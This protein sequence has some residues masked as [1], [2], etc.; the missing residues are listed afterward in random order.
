MTAVAIVGM[1]GRFAGAPDLAS[2]WRLVRDGRNAFGPVPAD[3]WD[4][5]AFHATSGRDADR[6][7]APA[8]AFLDDVRT[9]PALAFGIPP[10]R[11]E[12]MD[13]QQRFAIEVAIEALEDA[14]FKL[15]ELPRSTGVYVGI[16][17]HEFRLLHGARVTA[18]MMASGAFGEAPE[19]AAALARAVERVI[20]PRPFSA[21]GV[22]GNMC[23]AAIAQEL[24]LHGPA[25]TLDAACASALVAL[26]DAATQLRTGHIDVALAGGAYLQLNPEHYIAFSRIGA[27]SNAGV[28]RPFDAQADGFVQGD[29][30]GMVV[31][32]RLDDAVR[33]G[34]RIYATL[35]GVA[36]N[37][38]GRG[39]GPMAPVAEGQIE[40][41][42]AAWRDAGLDPARLGHL[43]AHGTGTTVGDRTELEG[44]RAAFP[45]AHAVALGSAKANVGHTMSA[46]G[47][48][49]VL[50]AALAIHH[51]Q[52]PPLANFEASNDDLPLS[53][54]FRIPTALE[55]WTRAD[56]LAGVS[57]FGFGG[58]N[59]HAVL[60]APPEVAAAPEQA[61]LVLL[62]AADEASL[63]TYAAA[64]A[65]A[66]RDDARATVAG[67]AAGLARRRRQA[68]R[69]GIVART[70]EDLLQA[71]DALAAGSTLP[72]HAHWGT[73]PSEPLRLAFLFPGQGAQRIGMLRDLARRFP[74]VASTLAAQE[75]VLADQLPAPLTHLMWPELQ[76]K[77]VSAEAAATALKATEVCQP[78]MLAAG[79]ALDALLASVG[80]RPQVVTG[81]SLGE[82]AAAVVGGVLSAEDAAGFVARRG[83]AMAALPGDTGAM[84]AVMA[85]VDDVRPLLVAPAVIANENHPRQVVVSGSTHAVLATQAAADAAG[86]RTVRLEVS[87]AFHSPVLASLD[88]ASIL[89][90]TR[91]HPPTTPV[92]S[93]IQRSPY[94]DAE[95]ARAV[96]LEHATRPVV[97]TSA[98]SQCLDAGA[99][100]FLQVGAGGPL[101]SF[102]RGLPGDLRGVWTLA[103]LEDDDG[104][105]SLLDTLAQLWV[106]GAQ[107]D[108]SA[109]TAA[110][111]PVLLPP[112]PLPRESY[113]VVKDDVTRSLT[114]S[115]T[116]ATHRAAAPQVAEREPEQPAA[117]AGADDILAG[118][119]AV[120][121]KV[122]AYPVSSLKPSM[123]LTED[124]GF[125]SLMVGDLAKGLTERF[126][127]L[128]GIPQEL[129][130]GG[131][132]VADLAEFVRTGQ[133]ATDDHDD[134]APLLVWNPTWVART[135]P[136][137]PLRP[138]PAGPVIVT[139]A[140]PTWLGPV[141]EQLRA[142][143]LPAI[144]GVGTPNELVAQRP[145]LLVWVGPERGPSVT[146]LLAGASMP[147]GAKSLLALL[148]ALDRA[149]TST[150]VLALSRTGD[151][152]SAAVAGALRAV[153]RE[154]PDRVVKHVVADDLPA[155]LPTLRTEWLT[156]DRTVD[157]A[158]HAGRRHISALTPAPEALP[159][160]QNPQV[161]AITGGTRGLGLRL[162]LRLASVGH[163]V[164]LMGRTPPDGDD[165]ALI[166]A[167]AQ[168]QVVSADVLDAG[169]LGAVLGPLGVTTLVHAAGVLA[170]G[171]LS[172]LTP[173]AIDQVFDTKVV[174][175]LNA[176]RACGPS[177]RRVH[178]MG[179]WAGRFGN[180][181]QAVYAAANAQLAALAVAV[182]GVIG[183]VGEYGPFV[184]SKMADSIPAPLRAAMRADGV[185]FVGPEAGLTALT[186]DLQ[187]TGI[188][189]RGRHLP[190][191]V[192]L[193][194]VSVS[195]TRE[196]DPYLLD[197]AIDGH[198]VLPL[199]AV[200][201]LL[202][203]GA[204]QDGPI[205][206]EDLTLYA[207]VVVDSPRELVVTVQNGRAELR[208]A[209]GRLHDRAQ[210]VDAP[211][212]SVVPAALTGGEPGPIPLRDF[213]SGLTFHG[214]L[215][216][217]IRSIDGIG[218][219][220]VRGTVV[221][222]RPTDWTPA[223]T[224]TRFTIDP[225]ALDSAFQLAAYAAWVR[226]R[227]AGTP[228]AVQRVVS[229][230]PTEPD[231][232]YT[233]DVHFGDAKD[234]R[235]SA[236]VVLRD[237]EGEPVLAAWGVVAELRKADDEVEATF[238]AATADP[239]QW[240]EIAD[241]EL[242]L[243]GVQALGLQNPYFHVHEG[244]AR[245]TTRVG[246]R[247]L[248]NFSS[249]NYLGYSGDPRVLD[250]VDEAVRRYGTSVSAS[251]V[252]SGER[253][254]HRELEAELAA[255]QGAEDAILFTA[256]HATNVTTIGH[257]MGPED[258]V[259]HDAYIHDSA[260]QGIKLAGSARRSFRHDDPEHLDHELQ[261]LRK[262]HRRC[263]IIIEGVYSMDGDL[264]D[265]PSYVAIKK[266]HGAL[267]MV[268]EAHSF[269]VVGPRGC[270]IGEHHG[271]DGR[272][273]DLWM[274]T[275]S[276][277]LSSCGG[278]IAGSKRLI[279]YLRYTAPGFVY[280]AGL[281]PAN[282][283]AAL[284]SL[285][286][287]LAEPERVQKLQHNAAW[288]HAAAAA[289]GLDTGPAR[290]GSAV[291]PIV[292]G[293]SM[294]ALV[295][296]Q[297][298]NVAGINVQP[299]VYPAVAD[300]AA[301]LRFFLS[302]THD[303]QQLTWTANTVADTL[304]AV[305]EEL[306]LP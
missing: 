274:G 12:V 48:A 297:R 240:T 163:R 277:S 162:G 241:L 242:R 289:R 19:D 248:V 287:M 295:L 234:D 191:R 86:L 218:P 193:T 22:L 264:A 202:A 276:K 273:I 216:Q 11:V 31:L 132:S 26:A 39:D 8:G 299:I 72:R 201:D 148:S 64:I 58:T 36:M 168:I 123:K 268:D 155:L 189:V 258:L 243:E 75:V 275:L 85:S 288:F 66:V 51:Q 45:G 192:S 280:S 153:A 269:G 246:G 70:V 232:I 178:A 294:H 139:G 238:D 74:V 161:V 7:T 261:R 200:A 116:P 9:F 55:P 93:G 108:P 158:W 84:V 78:A 300:D 88:S 184:G 197:H 207:G 214:P 188:L 259:L 98:L 186:D 113:W 247:E 257:L 107:L 291:V 219:T 131:P 267:L 290:G 54:A 251:R 301:R 143:G 254:F 71:L 208:D 160:A 73:A 53:A 56:R 231:A 266:K 40:V 303:E 23:A 63:R 69:A 181:H 65:R 136:D 159:T 100:A 42:R 279:Q 239:N 91:L 92:A 206:L 135:W 157:V 96:F 244:T 133:L 15:G 30:V 285:R 147:S 129:L 154:W 118:V 272:E 1:A 304:A 44:L 82:F 4:A 110:A 260:L 149:A 152:G 220:F 81:H 182:P 255:A 114:L 180:R 125:D 28:C 150:D 128:P 111:P 198:P 253:P 104:G 17:A 156:A 32:K 109:I 6:T 122:S 25:Y 187:R 170:D 306:P 68:A 62:A 166:A 101:A 120:V 95:E 204:G 185:D 256:G 164:V 126:P 298:L 171:P 24:D 13:P 47:I 286:L 270:G 292:T 79:L 41:I 60:G 196:A 99:N 296:S 190:G 225:L 215:L 124:L 18:M 224:R 221:G 228:V 33:D 223:S 173:E 16:T 87:H 175:F 67:V 213:Y 27:M 43:E 250:A 203:W 106:A 176:V 77:P 263:M 278:W 141:A 167:F 21:P 59:G 179:S 174:G 119:L 117:E 226:Y 283:V 265:L 165:A 142:G 121:A 212:V 262:N 145:A 235:F 46:A 236:D 151:L 97:F 210:V 35:E 76:H 3:R 115:A 183:S 105:V 271:V 302:S 282:G 245:N 209:A 146:D 233:A 5:A 130:V 211:P 90:T 50:K 281:T 29:G 293:N 252:A 305:R 34:D 249:Y 83:R 284:A 52:I 112:T 2:F 195:L 103:S 138:A 49:G 169:S 10:R 137:L 80:V 222:G 144:V 229:W 61:E 140:E 227:R 194:T 94:A 20:P 237:A 205:A 89:G 217:G 102:A 127:A 172:G 37:N 230:R 57:S 134:D 14:G 38:D 177:L 199:A